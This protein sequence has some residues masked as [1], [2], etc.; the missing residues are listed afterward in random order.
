MFTFHI[1]ILEKSYMIDTLDENTK[2][3]KTLFKIRKL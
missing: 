1:F 3:F 2:N